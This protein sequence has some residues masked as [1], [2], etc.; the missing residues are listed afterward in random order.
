MRTLILV[1]I[2]PTL[3]IPPKNKSQQ[4]RNK[5]WQN[6]DLPHRRK[7]P[8]KEKA[9]TLHFLINLD[10]L[11]RLNLQKRKKLSVCNSY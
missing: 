8:T 6:R 1:P 3:V 2:F 10:G 4:K 5:N 11:R 9:Q 7:L